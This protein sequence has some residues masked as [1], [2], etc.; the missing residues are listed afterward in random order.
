MARHVVGRVEELPPGSHKVVPVGRR[1]LGVF[2]VN[3]QF[4]ALYNVCPH[5]GGPLCLGPVTGTTR[6]TGPYQVEWVREGEILR[7]PWHGW[8]FDITTGCTITE[9][10]E[11]VQT[12]PVH[13]EDGLIVVET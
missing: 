5:A 12:Y 11:R 4:Y 8:E 2:N 10:V 1:G 6:A 7:C 9:P 3:G 13:I